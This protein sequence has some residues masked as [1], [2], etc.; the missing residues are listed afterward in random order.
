MTIIKTPEW[1]KNSVFYQIFPDRFAKSSRI[2]REGLK[3]EEWN[4]KPTPYGFKGGDLFGVAER[5]D[6]LQ[7]LGIT[8]IYF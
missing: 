7:D 4:S 2:D 3:L 6:Y 8:A 5:L 1:V